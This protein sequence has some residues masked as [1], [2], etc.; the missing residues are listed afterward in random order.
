MNTLP[1]SSIL[2]GETELVIILH[3]Y[4]FLLQLSFKN[5]HE[6]LHN[7]LLY[8]QVQPTKAS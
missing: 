6:R 5:K 8:I 1:Q 2:I 3:L 7:R 4:L